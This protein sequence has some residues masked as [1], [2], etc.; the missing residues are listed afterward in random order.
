MVRRSSIPISA[1]GSLPQ[2]PPEESGSAEPYPPTFNHLSPTSAVVWPPQ[3]PEQPLHQPRDGSPNS[4]SLVESAAPQEIDLLQELASIE[5]NSMPS[6][7]DI[8]DLLLAIGRAI[9]KA[10]RNKHQLYRLLIRSRDLCNHLHLML[11]SEIGSSTNTDIFKRCWEI[12]D[13]LER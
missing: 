4:G 6:T 8:V 12:M 1:D 13:R 10:I 9:P 7:K 3:S 5:I 2:Q 11:H